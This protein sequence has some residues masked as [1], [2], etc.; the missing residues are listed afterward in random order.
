MTGVFTFPG[1]GA[2][3]PGMFATL[4]DTESVRKTFDQASRA[5]DEDVRS[6]DTA[7]ALAD[8]RSVQ[9]A[10]T[11]AGIAAARVLIAAG[12]SP[13]AVLGL[14][15][16]AWSAAV[17]ANVIGLDDAIRLV[18][19][20]GR[21][22]EQAY[23]RGYGMAAVIGLSR[24]R[25]RELLASFDNESN[26]TTLYLANINSDQQIVIA[27]DDAS[28]ADLEPAARQ[29][30]AQRVVRLDM[31]VPSHCELMAEPARALSKAAEP[32][33]F[34][35]PERA[36]FSAN[37][38]RRLWKASEIRDDLVMNMA[39]PVYWVDTARIV[40]ESGYRLAVEMPP[41]HTLTRLH[42]EVEPPGE[43]ISVADTGWDNAAE[44]IR[45]TN[46]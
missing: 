4:P 12:A 9:I 46:A 18:A 20:R 36:Y 25:V 41:G 45:R 24:E 29:A 38:Q 7:I 42:P 13:N 28:L 3:R 35:T 6:L 8:T 31:A 5:L 27:G 22:M 19:E 30:G 43:A 15:I 33:E 1:Q 34:K 14:S 16:G 21:L 23:P 26:A 40:D 2:Q 10:L 32:I 37:R 17:I 11:V 39:R 44:L